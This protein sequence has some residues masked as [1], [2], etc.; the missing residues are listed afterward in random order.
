MK[1]RIF[2]SLLEFEQVEEDI[3]NDILQFANIWNEK[4][5][6]QFKLDVPAEAV[7]EFPSLDHVE[8]LELTEIL[9][10]K[11]DEWEW[12]FIH[13]KG[14]DPYLKENIEQCDF[15]EIIGDGYPDDFYLNELE[16]KTLFNSCPSCNTPNMLLNEDHITLKIDNNH[17]M[18]TNSRTRLDLVNDGNGGL[19]ASS[20][21]I[22]AIK[23]AKG[24]SLLPVKNK[25]N[26]TSDLLF[27]LKA[28]HSIHKSK[29][30]SD[31]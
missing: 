31:S 14:G 17:K 23:G 29:S 19:F 12:L 10:Q 13:Q 27:Q 30:L 6:K 11:K 9:K 4:H 2:Y 8:F 3:W 18:F 25:D 20:K 16:V 7:I 5:E 24:I 26:S 22:D 1:D 15:I 21:F 28:E